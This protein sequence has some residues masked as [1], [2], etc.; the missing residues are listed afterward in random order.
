M[1][2]TLE[3]NDVVPE[4]DVPVILVVVVVVVVVV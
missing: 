3:L 2:E 4:A 1:L